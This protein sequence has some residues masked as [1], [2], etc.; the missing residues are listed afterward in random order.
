ML[1][2]N[3]AKTVVT[4]AD[5]LGWTA[6]HHAAYHEFDMIIHPIIKAQIE[7]QHPFVYQDMLSTP[8]LVAAEKGYTSTM[9]C[10]MQSW[11]S[12]SSTYTIVDGN[13]QNILHLAALQSKREMVQGILKYCSQ[14]F[15]KE[16]VNKQDNN[17]DT[18]LHILIRRG[19]F[20]P[21]LLRCEGLDIK[22]ENKK[23]WNPPD[24]LY[25]DEQVID[26]Q[27]LLNLHFYINV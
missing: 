9:I 21:E 24:M 19:C 25:F 13:E 4:F 20:V 27:V 15:K 7:F 10:L 26:D 8:F 3:Y 17:G 5:N 23:R 1:K 11:P 16:F 6:L 2:E 12:W 18:P 14:E 22:V